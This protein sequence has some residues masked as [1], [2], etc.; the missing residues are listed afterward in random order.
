MTD[1]GTPFVSFASLKMCFREKLL[2]LFDDLLWSILQL[3]I[4][5]IVS[6]DS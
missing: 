6:G 1:K 5:F 2:H 4:N 3:Q